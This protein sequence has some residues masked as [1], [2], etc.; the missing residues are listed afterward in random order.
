MDI[1]RDH[2]ASKWLNFYHESGSYF[3]LSCLPVRDNLMSSVHMKINLR[4]GA[5]IFRNKTHYEQFGLSRIAID[6]VNELVK[7]PLDFKALEQR[8]LNAD[9]FKTCEIDYPAILQDE[10]ELAE[11]LKRLGHVLYVSSVMRSCG[12]KYEKSTYHALYDDRTKKHDLANIYKNVYNK[13]AAVKD[14][15]VVDDVDSQSYESESSLQEM[16]FKQVHKR[17]VFY[18]RAKIESRNVKK[19]KIK[20]VLPSV[21]ASPI[22]V[23]PKSEVENHHFTEYPKAILDST[24]KYTEK[25]VKKFANDIKK[26]IEATLLP[27][28]MITGLCFV[29]CVLRSEEDYSK[30]A[31]DFIFKV[32]LLAITF[33]YC[34]RALGQ[35]MA[36][37]VDEVRAAIKNSPTLAMKHCQ[38]LILLVTLLQNG[39]A[40]LNDAHPRIK[41]LEKALAIYKN[42]NKKIINNGQDIFEAIIECYGSLDAAVESEYLFL[43]QDANLTYALGESEIRRRVM[44]NHFVKKKKVRGFDRFYVGEL[45]ESLSYLPLKTFYVTAFNHLSVPEKRNAAV[46]VKYKF[47]SSHKPSAETCPSTSNTAHA[48]VSK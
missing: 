43:A 25:E 41:F 39:S 4:T 27:F 24:I 47:N 44:N 31:Y 12:F 34:D 8:K 36:R 15:F 28:C 7:L 11:R 35:G 23:E 37:R 6:G 2:Y 38:D 16:K 14:A 30:R 1:K 3:T 9:Q 22:Q 26:S 46:L 19:H 18:Q 13:K 21:N 33:Y 40:I 10:V 20:Q 42:T 48:F 17:I 29:T 5:V 45:E 32:L